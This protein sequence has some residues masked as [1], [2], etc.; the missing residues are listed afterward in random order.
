MSNIL[1]TQSSTT[2]KRLESLDILRGFVLF[3]LV[4]LEPIINGLARCTN[5]EAF[6]L[7]ASQFQHE[8]WVG[9][10]F[11]DMV[12]PLFLFMTGMAMPFSFSKYNEKTNK[13]KVYKRILRR[14]ALLWLFGLIVQG[15]ILALDIKS[16]YLFSNTLQAIAVGYLVASVILL[17][18]NTRQQIFLTTLLLLLYAV[19]MM[20]NGN[21]S[22]TS[23][24]ANSIDE[25]ILGR[26]RDGV[27]WISNTEWQFSSHYHYTWVFSSLT[28]PV[29]VMLG[30][31]ANKILMHFKDNSSKTLLCLASVGIGLIILGGL[32]HYSLPIIK[33]IWTSSMALF[34]GG[35][36]FLFVCLFYY[37]IDVKSMKGLG[38]LKVYGMNSIIA[39]VIGMVINF[40]GVGHSFL[41]GLE[42]YL[43]PCYYAVLLTLFNFGLLFLILHFLYKKRIFI[44]L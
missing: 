16:I 15:N 4:F 8:P 27:F 26:F 29:T 35:I 9:I 17:H 38:W 28:F 36:C 11:W 39:Y 6:N 1:S 5:S 14:V 43:T 10:K 37:L 25:A 20:L 3:L 19:P 40:R 31:F 30:V 12:M 33:P 32:W 24:F 22:P 2:Q 18:F 7:L 21:F 23:N 41:F 34:T 13:S 44:R 42:K